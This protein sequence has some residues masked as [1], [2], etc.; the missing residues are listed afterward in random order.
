M[1]F[2]RIKIMHVFMGSMGGDAACAGAKTLKSKLAR[3][4]HAAN[5]V[6]SRVIITGGILRD[7]SLLSDIIVVDL[8]KLGVSRCAAAAALMRTCG[9]SFRPAASH[10]ARSSSCCG[11]SLLAYPIPFRA[12]GASYGSSSGWKI[13][14]VKEGITYRSSAD[15]FAPDADAW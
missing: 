10:H 5:L 6:G 3:S 13:T 14:R 7:G 9:S 11:A 8:A 1:L 12:S 15:D 4:G 2:C